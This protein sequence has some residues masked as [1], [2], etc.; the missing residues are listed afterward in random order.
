MVWIADKLSETVALPTF[1]FPKKLRDWTTG[2]QNVRVG[3]LK[4]KESDE[5]EYSVLGGGDIGFPLMLSVAVFFDTGLGDAI[6]VGAFAFVGLMAAF[7][8][9]MLWLKGKPMPALPPIA[10][11]SLIGFLLT[12]LL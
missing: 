2:L 8:I 12:I 7:L 5:R 11:F 1:I 10:G 9:Q 3:E 6:L 4:D